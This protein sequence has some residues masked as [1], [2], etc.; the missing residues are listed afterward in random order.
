MSRIFA[1]DIAVERSIMER[2]EAIRFFRDM[3]EEYK[4]KII[5]D[6]PA[7]ETLSLYRQGDFIDLC[8]GPHVPS[9]GKLG[10]FKLRSE[11]H[12]SELQSRGH[13]V[14]RLLLEK[15]KF[16]SSKKCLWPW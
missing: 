10:A 7:D 12:T 4:A 1:D 13:L 9:T 16:A 2:D 14:C 8:R 11:E 5:E 6:I 15:I 3:G